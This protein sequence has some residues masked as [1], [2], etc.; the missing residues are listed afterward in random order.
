MKSITDSWKTTLAGAAL[1]VAVLIAH[2]VSWQSILM[3]LAAAIGGMVAKDHDTQ[4]S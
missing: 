4:A 3:S 1:G 2:G